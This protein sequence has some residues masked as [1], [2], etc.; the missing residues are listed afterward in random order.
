[1]VG[2]HRG[3]DEVVDRHPRQGVVANDDRGPVGQPKPDSVQSILG[4]Q[5]HCHSGVSVVKRPR[6]VSRLPEEPNRLDEL[7]VIVGHYGARFASSI[8]VLHKDPVAAIDFN[9]LRVLD[10]EERL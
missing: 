5:R 8:P 7:S 1:M 9:I 2:H 10:F 4:S 3:I 6:R